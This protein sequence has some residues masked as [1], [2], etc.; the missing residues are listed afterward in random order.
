MLYSIKLKEKSSHEQKR[1]QQEQFVE[2]KLVRPRPTRGE[3]A[4][5]LYFRFETLFFDNHLTGC[6]GVCLFDTTL[7]QR[8]YK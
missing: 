6:W 5:R 3:R 8:I 2:S 1:Q 7:T 4:T